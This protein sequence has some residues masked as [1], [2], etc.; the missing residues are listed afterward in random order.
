[1]N[2][3]VVPDLGVTSDR[4]LVAEVVCIGLLARGLLVV[5]IPWADPPAE[6]GAPGQMPG[7]MPG[8]ALMLC[9]LEPESVAVAR[10]LVG[11]HPARWLLVT[12][13]PR[14]P[15]WGAMLDVG[16][17]GILEGGTTLA[18]LADAISALLNGLP[19]GVV[20]DRA[21]LVSAWR[22]AGAR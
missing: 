13:A 7:S 18:E 14:G 11:A 10:S 20:A 16:V 21:Q 9:D 1:M 5:R 19:A 2:D 4:A 12:S 15:L 8:L 22:A 17:D 3:T 6:R